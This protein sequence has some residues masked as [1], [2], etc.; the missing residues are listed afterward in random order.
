MRAKEYDLPL[1]IL[2]LVSGPLLFLAQ[3]LTDESL[4]D[5]ACTISFILGVGL[6]SHLIVDR[7]KNRALRSIA[8]LLLAFGVSQAA[9][10]FFAWLH[11]NVIRDWIPMDAVWAGGYLGLLSWMAALLA[12]LL[13]AIPWTTLGSG[14]KR[15]GLWD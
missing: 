12:L 14:G 5:A 9:V 3:S 7:L 6:G 10:R 4:V 13:T 15:V 11:V 1:G 2:L 8:G